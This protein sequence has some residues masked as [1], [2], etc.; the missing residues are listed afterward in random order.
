M[1]RIAGSIPG[2]RRAA[3]GLAASL[4]ACSVLLGCLP[5]GGR[6]SS[7]P[8]LVD[9]PSALQG[10]QSLVV[11]LTAAGIELAD[12]A[13]ITAPALTFTSPSGASEIQVYSLEAVQQEVLRAEVVV[14]AEAT[15][16]T[17]NVVYTCNSHTRFT[18]TFEVRQK[19]D[20]DELVLDPSEGPAGKTNLEIEITAATSPFIDG[21][22]HVIFGDGTAVAVK[23]QQLLGAGTMLV[24]VD[25]SYH[26]PVGEM[27]VAVVTGSQVVRGTFEVTQR[28]YPT[29]QVYP[30][31]VARPAAADPPA[32]A[33]LLIQGNAVNFVDADEIDAGPEEGTQVSFPLNPGITV[34]SIEVNNSLEVEANIMVDHVA[35]LGPTPL[36]VT[37]GDEVAETDFTVFPAADEPVLMLSPSTLP[38]GVSAAL[39]LAQA[40]NFTFD[41]PL[42]I[43]FTDTG[44]TVESY[45]V[46]PPVDSSKSMALM[47]SID[48]S[49]TGNG[50]VLHVTSGSGAAAAHLAVS[51]DLGPLLKFDDPVV[52]E[53]VQGTTVSVW[54]TI[55]GGTFAPTAVARVLDRSGLR[56][57]SQLSNAESL[58]M[59]LE[60]AKDA[61]IGP[62]LLQ[63][64]NAGQLLEIFIE[65]IPSGS[66]PF[67]LL[68]PKVVLPGRRTVEM[69][70]GANGIDLLASPPE[71]RFD[72]PAVAVEETDVIDAG[73]ATLQVE[74]APSARSDMTV[75]Y[76]EGQDGRAAATFR[77]VPATRLIAE[78]TPSEI[79]R[80]VPGP[81]VVEVELLGDSGTF[82]STVAQVPSGIGLE[83]ERVT[84]LGD[85][86]LELEFSLEDSGPGGSLGVLLMTGAQQVVVPIRVIG[87]DQTLTL[88]LTPGTI[89]P[90][91]RAAQYLAS[92]PVYADFDP[93]FTAASAGI[94]GAYA[95]LDELISDS[96]ATVLVDVAFDAEIPAGGIPVFLTTQKGAVV[97]FLQSETLGTG[98]ASAAEPFEEVLSEGE[99]RVVTVETDGLPALISASLSQP[100]HAD[101]TCEMLAQTPGWTGSEAGG[102]LV[103]EDLCDLGEVWLWS[104]SYAEVAVTAVG[105]PGVL[106]SA[107]GVTS[108]HEGAMALT[109]PD[110]LP[111]QAEILEIDPCTTPALA[112]GTIVAA[113]DR[114]RIEL[115][116]TSCRLLASAIA[117]AAADRPW[118]SP[119][120]WLELRDDA[121]VTLASS[122]GWP[123]AEDD[124]PR[125]FFDA[126]IAGNQ[127]V[128]GAEL[129]TAGPYL[130]NVR[131]TAT[132]REICTAVGSSYIELEL[133]PGTSFD[134]ISI[135]LVDAETGTVLESLSLAG[136][137]IVNDGVVVLA[138][139]TMSE[140]DLE[141]QPV[142]VLPDGPFA[143]RLLDGGEI[144][145]AVEVDGDGDYGEGDP[146]SGD[147]GECFER[148][149]GV[150]S[151]DNLFDFVGRWVSTPG[152]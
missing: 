70:V 107:V 75:A 21:V 97:G 4:I 123:T 151:D 67:V 85:T 95:S 84:V 121:E 109:E 5:D 43:E 143:V 144:V 141:D 14:D 68:S 78:A 46:L 33:T 94:P 63:V 53:I 90:G 100:G 9:P 38:R 76:I 86:T 96:A 136:Q 130:V 79:T 99:T 138:G 92:A 88:G 45:E 93:V 135:E 113:L 83:I 36:R 18:G 58:A 105:D 112:R 148:F 98:T 125:I 66:V 104:Q 42:D 19:G 69:E 108:K 110:D 117:R 23:E 41:P 35:S 122:T 77:G 47:V 114:E 48:P 124:D 59:Q 118:D 126:G 149:L 128:W 50:T 61:P 27:E 32:Q 57:N 24:T 56:I 91:T 20:D 29:V 52:S 65:V 16:G 80:G 116:E 40:A 150:D 137:P 103:T 12:C 111:A 6:S 22:S 11:N 28:I 39:V 7:P 44:C 64:D 51:D 89:E 102:A 37:T 54:L 139:S 131:R 15:V 17:Y 49:F 26:A 119:D 2:A 87:S 73:T 115:P 3:P 81:H 106:P 120:L 1:S 152:S 10:A 62:A 25:I 31:D 101:V 13:N 71:I 74:V 146:L 82:G 147:T 145:D 30:D 140:A 8:L 134:T 72:D 133:E 127:L 55:E 60:A 132:L 34:T 142:A 129:G